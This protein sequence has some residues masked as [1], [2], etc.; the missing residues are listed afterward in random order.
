MARVYINGPDDEHI[1]GAAKYSIVHGHDAAAGTLAGNEPCQV[2]CPISD[3]RCCLL[4]QCCYNHFTYLSRS[5]RL[6]RIRI[7]YLQNIIIGPIMDTP[8]MDAIEACPGS[9]EFR[10]PGYIKEHGGIDAGHLRDQFSHGITASFC[11]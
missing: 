8:V 4:F 1:I 5:Y 6:K 3:E 11:A 7:Q 9:I 10:Q 2:S